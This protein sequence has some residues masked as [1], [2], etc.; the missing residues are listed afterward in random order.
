M[1]FLLFDFKKVGN[2]D[3][4]LQLKIILSNESIKFRWIFQ[5]TQYWIRTQVMQRMLTNKSISFRWLQNILLFQQTQYWIRTQVMQRP[6]L[7]SK[8]FNS[9][10]GNYVNMLAIYRVHMKHR[11]SQVLINNQNFFNIIIHNYCSF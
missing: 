3:I 7:M 2:N 1:F 10:N 11:Q 4:D 8:L 6:Q 5:Q 9:I